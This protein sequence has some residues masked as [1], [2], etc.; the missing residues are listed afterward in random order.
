MNT[1]VIVCSRKPLKKCAYCENK[2]TQL[3]DYAFASGGTCDESLC[4]LHSFSPQIGTDF[5]RLHRRI[6]E[7]REREE[8]AKI[9]R[10][11]RKRDTLIFFAMSKFDGRCKD[12]DCGARWKKGEPCYWDSK[13]REVFCAECGE[14]MEAA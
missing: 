2:G 7:G 6:I 10:E 4:K 12:K 5:C 14:Q 1:T 11:M 8:K 13:T 9:E 3:C